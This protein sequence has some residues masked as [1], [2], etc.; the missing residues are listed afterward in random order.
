MNVDG[1]GRAP[2]ARGRPRRSA[3]PPTP[4]LCRHPE[5]CTRSAS[6]GEAASETRLF[7]ARHRQAHHEDKKHKLCSVPHCRR[8]G[9]FRRID[10][11][12]ERVCAAHSSAGL[13]VAVGTVTCTVAGCFAPAPYALRVAD[14]DAG[15][16]DAVNCSCTRAANSSTVKRVARGTERW[17]AAHRPVG[18]IHVRTGL[19]CTPECEARATHGLPGREPAVCAVHC[20]PG[21]VD[22]R[23]KRCQFVPGQLDASAETVGCKRQPSYGDAD[24]GVARFCAK[25]RGPSHVDVRSR[26]LKRTSSVDSPAD[27]TISRWPLVDRGIGACALRAHRTENAVEEILWS[28]TFATVTLLRE[29]VPHP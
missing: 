10:G 26:R 14:G 8:Q 29:M 21:D 5:G 6:F 17:C 19:C 3:A 22:R 16:N 25:H 11:V 12:G 24:E 2:C 13:R 9:S 18:S 20:R 28:D 1:G 23:H 27:A 15:A 7:C 4:L